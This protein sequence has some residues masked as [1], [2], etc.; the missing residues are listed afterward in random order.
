MEKK[1]KRTKT[2]Q[3]AD[4]LNEYSELFEAYKLAARKTHVAQE[5]E[6]AAYTASHAKVQTILKLWAET[7]PQWKTSGTV[8]LADGQIANIGGGSVTLSRPDIEL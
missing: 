3:L 6:R 5:A 7:Q 1:H 8:R 4:A 2:E